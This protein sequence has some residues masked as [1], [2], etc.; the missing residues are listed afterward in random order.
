[1]RLDRRLF[2]LMSSTEV[3]VLQEVCACDVLY[4]PLQQDATDAPTMIPITSY[5]E[6][7]IHLLLTG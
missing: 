4:R 2:F 3:A 5:E 6:P 1:M 7:A